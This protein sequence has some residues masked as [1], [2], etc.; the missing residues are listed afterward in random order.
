ME[1]ALK[2]PIC[3]L[4]EE[5]K[6]PLRQFHAYPHLM[7]LTPRTQV[8]GAVSF[9]LL[10]F[11]LLAVNSVL[12]HIGDEFAA[13]AGGDAPPAV[14]TPPAQFVKIANLTDMTLRGIDSGR[15][16]S[17]VALDMVNEIA[18]TMDAWGM[19]CGTMWLKH[20][21]RRGEPMPE[22]LVRDTEFMNV[23]SLRNES[24][25]FYNVHIIERSRETEM[26]TAP[27]KFKHEKDTRVISRVVK[28]SHSTGIH[29][30]KNLPESFCV[31]ELF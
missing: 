14:W 9:V 30:T 26:V 6:K 27:F 21:W 22:S 28:F 15:L 31:Q 16:H 4:T 24:R 5:G 25:P 18:V 3:E 17:A 11:V 10:L 2:Q 8:L 1:S 7:H 13:A 29:A 20:S 23:L 12:E 19:P